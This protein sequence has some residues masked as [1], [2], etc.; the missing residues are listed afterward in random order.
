MVRVKRGNV[1][2]N[3]RKKILKLAKGFQGAH[4]RLFRTANGQVMKALIY[5]YVGRKRR[6]RDFKRL[7]ICRINAATH[8]HGL[9]YNKFRNALKNNS[10]ELNLKMLA[11]L[12]LLDKETFDSLIKEVF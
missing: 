4:S 9:S 5:S 10:I 2:R 1:A 8:L 3:R 6:K 12:T 7:W 11:Q